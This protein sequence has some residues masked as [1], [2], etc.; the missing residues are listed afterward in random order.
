MTIFSVSPFFPLL[1]VVG[2]TLDS[3]FLFDSFGHWDCF[4]FYFSSRHIRWPGF[5]TLTGVRKCDRF[6]L[7]LS[8]TGR[9]LCFVSF[10]EK[11][12]KPFLELAHF[13]ISLFI[14]SFRDR[15]LFYC[16]QLNWRWEREKKER[17]GGW[18]RHTSHV[19]HCHQHSCA[20]PGTQWAI[21]M[22]VVHT[23]YVRMPASQPFNFRRKATL[24]FDYRKF[25]FAILR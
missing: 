25:L 20:P 7:S 15:V 14:H 9:L 24:A 1:S 2:H 5:A 23:L 8:H 19:L 6:F 13:S 21:G 22:A 17:I 10:R 4:M 3:I 18:A 16:I 11:F 12:S